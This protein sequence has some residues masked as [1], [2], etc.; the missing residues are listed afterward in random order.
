MSDNENIEQNSVLSESENNRL[1]KALHCIKQQEIDICGKLINS[2][3]SKENNTFPKSVLDQWLKMNNCEGTML[4]NKMNEAL[5]KYRQ[6]QNINRFKHQTIVEEVKS[7]IIEDENKK[8]K[9]EGL[10]SMHDL[11][12]KLVDLKNA[13]RVLKG[14]TKSNYHEKDENL[15]KLISD[16]LLFN[17]I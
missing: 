12:Q 4:I 3:I 15:S 6:T 5:E 11:L 7:S 14:L 9:L 17:T 1:K 8:D 2:E 16:W 13:K 10:Q